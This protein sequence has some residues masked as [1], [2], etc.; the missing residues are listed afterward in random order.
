M[1]FELYRTRIAFKWRQWIDFVE[2][3][4]NYYR[5]PLFRK[6]DL[7]LLCSYLFENPYRISRDYLERKG[8]S[9]IY[10]YGETPLKSMEKIVY[11]CGLREGDRLY[12]LGCGRGRVCFWL[13]L[14]RNLE[15]IGIDFVPR[16]IEKA[17]ALK[18]RFRL[19]N[20]SFLLEN[21]LNSSLERATAIYL[22]G[23]CLEEK[24]I[25][26]LIQKL[27]ALE[28]NM[29]VITVSF[30]LNEYPQG[31]GWKVKKSFT[32]PFS[33]GEAEVYIQRRED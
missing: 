8:V 6:V 22:H 7:A 31:R 3:A 33:W 25:E 29:Q 15:V 28:R 16:F 17:E 26:A 2:T 14:H 18:N 30:A 32:L 11:E 12:E 21:F 4:F 10:A 9:E 1:S 23:T 19:K 24:D 20:P 27:N 13:A 5:N